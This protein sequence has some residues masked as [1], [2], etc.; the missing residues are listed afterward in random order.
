[1]L[2][3]VLAS[4]GM[5]SFAQGELPPLS[6]GGSDP[7]NVTMLE[8]PAVMAPSGYAI[9][10]VIDTNQA[11]HSQSLCKVAHSTHQMSKPGVHCPWNCWH[12]GCK[13]FVVVDVVH[14]QTK[15]QTLFSNILRQMSQ[16]DPPTN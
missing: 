10:Q 8:G 2:S 1:M 6:R 4:Q 14:G 15:P 16:S 12:G 7:S 9:P 5:E 3:M 11:F 13:D